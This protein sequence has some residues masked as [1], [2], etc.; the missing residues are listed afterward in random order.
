MHRAAPNLLGWCQSPTGTRSLSAL[1]KN[2][3]AAMLSAIF[4]LDPTEMLTVHCNVSRVLGR[5]RG[6]AGVQYLLAAV[7][8]PNLVCSRMK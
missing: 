8:E 4:D 7:G 2:S 3:R 6:V 1:S 5:R